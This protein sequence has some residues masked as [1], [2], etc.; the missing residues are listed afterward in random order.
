MLNP[1]GINRE[2]LE[3]YI[4]YINTGIPLLSDSYEE[5]R[6]LLLKNDAELM[7]EPF[8][9]LIRKYGIGISEIKKRYA[10][11]ENDASISN[12][13]KRKKYVELVKMY[14]GDIAT[15]EQACKEA[16]FS[17]PD[18]DLITDFMRN[19]LL[20]GRDLYIHQMNSLVRFCTE[21]PSEKQKNIVV[22]TGTGSGKTECFFIP[23]MT[24]LIREKQKNTTVSR[25]PG[26]R[27]MILYPLNALA[28]DQICRLRTIIDSE[29]SRQ[30]I[31]TNCNGNKI[32]FG[33]YT[34]K[35][36]KSDDTKAAKDDISRVSKFRKKW[37]EKV[38]KQNL[39]LSNPNSTEEQINDAKAALQELEEQQ[40]SFPF[41]DDNS[42]EEKF[43][44][45]MQE[46][47][48]DIFITNYSMLRV[49]LM[50]DAEVQTIIKQTKE[51]LAQ[52]G[53]FFTLI[54]DE[55]H[56]YFGTSG[57]EISY[58][59]KTLL[60]RLEITNKKLRIIASSASLNSDSPKTYKFLDEFFSIENSKD[61]FSIIADKNKNIDLDLSKYE[62]LPKTILIELQKVLQEETEDEKIIQV[63]EDIL[64]KYNLTPKTFCETYKIPEILHAAIGG[65]GEA[66]SSVEIV[67]KIFGNYTKENMNAFEA[68]LVI[69][70]Q[71]KKEDGQALQPIR[72]HYFAKNI[73]HIY[74]CSNP[75][76]CHNS[77]DKKRK[78]GKLYLT[79]NQTCNKCGSRVYEAVI[80]RHCGELFISGYRKASNLSS[81]EL[82]QDKLHD[83]DV[84]EFFFKPNSTNR[85]YLEEFRKNN[86]QWTG[87][88]KYYLDYITG[89]LKPTMTFANIPTNSIPM[90]KWNKD[91]AELYRDFNI[92]DYPTQ[93]PNCGYTVKKPKKTESSTLR[94][95][96]YQH[97]TGISKVSQVFADALIAKLGEQSRKNAKLVLFSDSR[98]SAARL[99]AGV[100]DFHFRDAVRAA[101]FA[102]LKEGKS[103]I[104][105]KIYN[106]LR[107]YAEGKID[108]VSDFTRK[109]RRKDKIIGELY[110]V[111]EMVRD[112]EKLNDDEQTIFNS[113]KVFESTSE[114][115]I[116]DIANKAREKI[117]EIGM[118]PAGPKPS[119][120]FI[121]GNKWYTYLDGNKYKSRGLTVQ[122]TNSINM[123]ITES[124][125]EV[126]K[127][128]MC[129]QKN[130]YESL[131]IGYFALKEKLN[132]S[133]GDFTQE[134]IESSIRILGENY[135]I[136]GTNNYDDSND[137]PSSLK[138]YLQEVIPNIRGRS[139]QVYNDLQCLLA[140]KGV[141]VSNNCCEIKQTGD[142]L[143]FIKA[144]DD[145]ICWRCD[146]CKKIHLQHSAGIC[147]G[148]YHE[149]TDKCK[150]K[151]SEIKPNYYIKQAENPQ[152]LKRLHCEEMTGQTE[153]NKRN[154]RQRLFKNFALED[155]NIT[156]EGVD[157]LSVT[158]TME[159]GVD[160]GSLSAVM[161][162]NFP[163]Q[164]FNYQ[165]RV[166]RAGR[167]GSAVSIALTIAKVNSHDLYYFS[168]PES[169]VSGNSA[170]PYV[171]KNNIEILKRIII[172]EIL[173]YACKADETGISKKDRLNNIRDVHGEFGTVN[174]WFDDGNTS[175]S[176]KIQEWIDNHSSDIWGIIN[177]Y[178]DKSI[179][180]NERN[181]LMKYITDDLIQ[182]ISVK[183]EEDKEFPIENLAEKLS[184]LGFLPM[185]GFPTSVRN[186]YNSYDYYNS[187][188]G[189]VKTIVDRNAD[190][191]LSTFAPGAEIVKDKRLFKAIGFM[192][193]LPKAYGKPEKDSGLVTINEKLYCCDYCKSYFFSNQSPR[194]CINCQQ[195]LDLVKHEYE[196]CNPLGYMTQNYEIKNKEK[197]IYIKDYDG[198][199]EWV[200]QVSSS[201]INSEIMPVK[202]P[203][204]MLKAG[205]NANN[206]VVNTINTN[207]NKGFEIGEKGG[208]TYDIR[209]AEQLSNI[210]RV[211][212]V[213]T[214]VTGVM[215]IQ[216]DTQNP[217]IDL[218]ADINN[219]ERLELIRGA[220]LS[221]GTLLRNAIADYSKI[222]SNEISVIYSI[223]NNGDT[224][225]P[226]LGFIENLTNGSGYLKHSLDTD[227]F[228]EIYG[229]L[230]KEK[231]GKIYNHLV[232]N[233]ELNHMKCET[234]CNKCLRDYYNQYIHPLLNWRLAFD[235][236][237]VGCSG[238]TPEYLGDENYWTPLVTKKI[239][240]YIHLYPYTNTKIES[241]N[242]I[243]VYTLETNCNNVSGY[244]F[245]VH[246][247]WSNE[248][249]NDIK[250]Y[251]DNSFHKSYIPI[252]LL[253]F[254][255]RL[256]LKDIKL[257]PRKMNQKPINNK[258]PLVILNN[259]K[260]VID[261]FSY[262]K[263]WD[264]FMSNNINENTLLT[265]LQSRSNELLNSIEPSINCLV[266]CA[267]QRVPVD[268]IWLKDNEPYLA[269]F[270]AANQDCFD[271]VK[272]NSNCQCFC[273]AEASVDIDSII[274]IIRS[275]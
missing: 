141:I 255:S 44:D 5:E 267:N 125:G 191:A 110:D 147:T 107:L 71:V 16:N 43:R 148:C 109:A 11:I 217:N 63:T 81:F 22:T 84:R 33:R 162:G 32:T 30:W 133:I 26:M 23:L 161:M 151:V 190:I 67:K 169:M 28:E 275:L 270:S 189:K 24:N 51:Y 134:I 54:I 36:E 223:K 173:Y 197:R 184:C 101:T 259:A 237:E 241:V 34:G 27:A 272:D 171:V 113:L 200:P 29:N 168:N 140:S 244:W 122:E 245:I 266:E 196:A 117:I 12:V 135:R 40:Y 2:L 17:Q 139:A 104:N 250:D 55:L 132:Q 214:K 143:K 96:I 62:A 90:I 126:L 31:K 248:F 206:G 21:N 150:C 20:K 210:R 247:I 215:Q 18:S 251:L 154:D 163:P 268:I 92:A 144:K 192:N 254:V 48:P 199:F 155:E 224:I 53:T 47:C 249:I 82:Q 87:H 105:V 6:S 207:S 13:E 75:D 229:Y 115:E 216:F 86:K 60:E 220:Y 253:S 108:T 10:E 178:S 167:R 57:T 159:A 78:Y 188:T 3:N 182:D 258:S 146:S 228:S 230:L 70:N 4:T 120:L 74:V 142:G 157:L 137:L 65:F 66:V 187:E 175:H 14:G 176:E 273:G 211:A 85:T 37:D 246:P 264:Y 269:Y 39:I 138:E 263:L 231:N 193:V 102:A 99:S 49:L 256:Q 89:E 239:N 136:E 203:G 46:H 15:I 41:Y 225:I 172:N 79:P 186:V 69:L 103:D 236:A 9:E 88:E 118:N 19:C 98:Q 121:E 213:T 145:D 128:M 112:G 233:E 123:A 97:G 100:E 111:C 226:I 180:F 127:A 194:V 91:S 131:G 208:V 56:S 218:T 165:Q 77:V 130:S 222:D 52:P 201:F 156:Y 149:L 243:P 35:T 114:Y 240:D 76:C 183:L 1:I 179:N 7:R 234:S 38:D 170:S 124:I 232:K 177:S 95:P 8:I 59:I 68:L 153:N 64:K 73:D 94:T 119:R 42:F 181:K 166:G 164:R 265:A 116:T 257:F 274:S 80:C 209:F 238:N 262:M 252:D 221:F 25:M 235:L 174:E 61:N 185:L 205:C 106:E 260:T 58:I 261:N 195:P 45:E 212:L 83:T 271:F 152:T 202:V 242:N 219:P 129:G 50:R 204:F 93:C 158:T 160:I 198:Q 72:S 227:I